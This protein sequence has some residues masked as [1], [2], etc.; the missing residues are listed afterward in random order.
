MLSALRE[1]PVTDPLLFLSQ[2]IEREETVEVRENNLAAMD[3]LDGLT[4]DQLN[5]QDDEEP[6]VIPPPSRFMNILPEPGPRRI[7]ESD[8]EDAKST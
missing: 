8:E 7:V 5:L 3:D 4:S 1:L 6:A 2:V